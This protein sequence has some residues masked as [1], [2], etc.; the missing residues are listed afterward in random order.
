MSKTQEIAVRS[1]TDLASLDDLEA[2]LLDDQHEIPPVADDP[3][4]IS[5]EI[6]AQLLAAESDEELDQVGTAVG[7][8]DLLG[9]PLELH[10]FKWRPSS[11]EEGQ[12][13]FF[14]LSAT[15]MDTGER[16]VATTGS[17]NVLAQLVNRAKRGTLVGAR[18]KAEQADKPTKSGFRPYWLVSVKPRAGVIDGTATEVA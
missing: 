9:V 8:R 16:I 7:L 15:R 10:G 4:E 17:G 11:F 2:I 14:V 5:K 3:A 6:M 18:V 12:R 13:V 1:S